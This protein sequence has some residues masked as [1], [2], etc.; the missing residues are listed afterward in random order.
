MA[1]SKKRV[2]LIHNDKAGDGRLGRDELVG[3]LSRAGYSVAYFAYKRCDLASALGRPAD[4][5]A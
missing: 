5:V 2:T 4:V 3:L 1:G